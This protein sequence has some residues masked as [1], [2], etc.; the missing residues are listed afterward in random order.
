MKLEVITSYKFSSSSHIDLPIKNWEEVK[1]YHVKWNTLH[2]T[3]D[4]EKWEE[5]SLSD[6]GEA[7][8]KKVH[9]VTFYNAEN[10]DLLD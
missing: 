6:P 4:G 1:D 2:Y 3:L 9:D 5:V 8:V 10:G 7:D